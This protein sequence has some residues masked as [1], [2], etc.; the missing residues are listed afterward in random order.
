LLFVEFALKM[1]LYNFLNF[2]C[3]I[4]KQGKGVQGIITK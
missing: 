4:T 1:A 3:H 2:F